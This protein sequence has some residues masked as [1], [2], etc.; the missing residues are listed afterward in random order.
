MRKGIARVALGPRFQSLLLPFQIAGDV[1]V[2]QRFDEE[3]LDVADP[4]AQLVG[5]AYA[6]PR[7]GRLAHGA[8]AEAESRMCHRKIRIDRNR[9]L[10]ERQAPYPAL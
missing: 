10:V 1:A 4:I 2:V 7:Q 8:V 3:A 5:L 9:T 6:R